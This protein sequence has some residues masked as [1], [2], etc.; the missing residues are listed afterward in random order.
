VAYI[1]EVLSGIKQ[2][3]SPNEVKSIVVGKDFVYLRKHKDDDPQPSLFIPFDPSLVGSDDPLF[4]M[5]ERTY[6]TAEELF[7]YEGYS[8]S[9]IIESYMHKATEERAR[10]STLII[11]SKEEI[12]TCASGV[13]AGA[14]IE[15][16]GYSYARSIVDF[17]HIYPLQPEHYSWD[18]VEGLEYFRGVE[19]L[20]AN[21][22]GTAEG[23]DDSRGTEEVA[24][25]D[26]NGVGGTEELDSE[27]AEESTLTADDYTIQDAVEYYAPHIDTVVSDIVSNYTKL[28]KAGYQLKRPVGVLGEQGDSGKLM[29]L[30]G[31]SQ[32]F[33][34]PNPVIRALYQLTVAE[35]NLTILPYRSVDHI[36]S[37]IVNGVTPDGATISPDTRLYFP[38]K[39]LEFA[40]G[41]K[42]PKATEGGKTNYPKHSEKLN[43]DS[44]ASEV[45]EN[46]K[47]LEIVSGS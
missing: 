14:S 43:W 5:D 30:S 33:T 24:D 37:I 32:T 35:Y 1:K 9:P 39:M 25:E 15:D 23:E 28:F 31:S 18:A 29:T 21:T 36:A 20:V 26:L 8:H 12:D 42:T 40:Y 19:E 16:L 2:L 17:S 46:Y 47:L 10:L 45:D 27:G 4:F 38:Y 11:G 13:D 7:V 44:Y 34:K 22:Y 3:N 41:R 6:G